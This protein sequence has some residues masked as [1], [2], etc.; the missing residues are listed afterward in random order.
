LKKKSVKLV[1]NHSHG[2]RNG[3]KIGTKL[4]FAPRDAKAIKPLIRN[5]T[6]VI[7]ILPKVLKQ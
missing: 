1:T 7:F 5:D 3:R 2:V 6:E 4:N